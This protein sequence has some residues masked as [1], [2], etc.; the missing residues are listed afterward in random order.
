MERQPVETARKDSPGRSLLEMK[1]CVAY[2]GSTRVFDGLSLSLQTGINTAILGP[3]GAGKSTLIKMITREVKP[4]VTEDY[5]FRLFT[6]ERWNVWELRDRLG[7]ISDDL[8]REYQPRA[9]GH[10]VVLSG[11]FSSIDIASNHEITGEQL[12]KSEEIMKSLEILELAGCPYGTLSTGQKRRFLLGRALI[13][14]PEVLLLDEPT[15]GLDV[16]AAH[17]YYRLMEQLMESGKTLVLVTHHINE[18]LPHIRRV[19]LL[20]EGKIAGD[21]PKEDILTSEKM[22][23][24]YETPLRVI[25]SNGYYQI[26]PDV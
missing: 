22:S 14:D 11:F 9:T 19:I 1:N 20:K 4:V 12:K 15:S 17:Q 7:L 8:Q 21:G 2:R 23:A 25:R 5:L 18:I 24:L 6:R 13:N 10:H 16:K 26:I 3:N